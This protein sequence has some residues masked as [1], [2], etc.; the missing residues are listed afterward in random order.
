MSS[1]KNIIGLTEDQKLAFDIVESGENVF[2]TGKA[3]TGKSFLTNYI[4]E[5]L[6]KTDKNVMI[7]AS[8]GIAAINI[9]GVTAHRAF[10]IPIGLGNVSQTDSIPLE[11]K[12]KF[13]SGLDVLII[14]E[15]SMLRY[16]I[17]NYVI[18]MLSPVIDN[19]QIILVGDFLQL[20]PILTSNEKITY[21]KLY[22]G[23]PLYAFESRYWKSLDFK[24]AMLT[25]VKRQEGDTRLIENL[26]KARLGD[27]SCISYFNKFKNNEVSR[28]AVHI[29]PTNK[30]AKDINKERNDNLEGDYYYYEADITGDVKKT[31]MVCDELLEVKIGSRVMVCI[32]GF[33]PHTGV[34]YYNGSLGTIIACFIGKVIIELDTG[35]EI[36]LG[37]HDWEILGYKF[38]EVEKLVRK[39][40]KDKDG[41]DSFEYVK[42]KKEELVTDVVGTFSQIPI[43]SAF[44]ITIHKSQG[45]SMDEVVVHPNC[46]A[47]GQLY[48]AL[49]RCTNEDGLSLTREIPRRALPAS[50][51]VLDFYR[52]EFIKD[53]LDKL[54]GENLLAE[55][56]KIDLDDPE[57][58]MAGSNEMA[59][60]LVNKDNYE[61]LKKISLVLDKFGDTDGKF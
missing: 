14:D 1:H 50:K 8:T 27:R 51:K 38:K 28:D 44:A 23:S 61:I 7:T 10:G 55:I 3:G 22:N 25:T 34:K 54:L 46:F 9:G 39:D 21:E 47:D 15:I 49:S 35:G 16:D 40:I 30:V 29:C 24:T 6:R 53:D 37:K 11:K 48:V 45:Q 19:V 26:N 18:N 4:I 42:E 36:A 57:Y 31:D 59:N 32:N 12:L 33:D 43:K 5:C 41:K 56:D 58:A 52:R 20:S 13:V 2:I 60:L 17:F